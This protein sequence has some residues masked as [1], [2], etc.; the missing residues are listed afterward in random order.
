MEVGSWC[1]IAEKGD[2]VEK[3]AAFIRKEEILQNE[4]EGLASSGLL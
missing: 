4:S 2:L 1:G 3:A